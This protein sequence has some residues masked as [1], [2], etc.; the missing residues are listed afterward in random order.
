MFIKQHVIC[1]E[2]LKGPK[3]SITVLPSIAKR[4]QISIEF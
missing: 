2:I 3:H 4:Q 1:L